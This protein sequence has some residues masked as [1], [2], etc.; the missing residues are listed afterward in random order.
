VSPIKSFTQGDFDR[1][2]TQHEW[3]KGCSGGCS[4]LLKAPIGLSRPGLRVLDSA[5]ADGTITPIA[6]F[7]LDSH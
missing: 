7:V 5:T 1:L 2:S 4:G 6:L 3:I